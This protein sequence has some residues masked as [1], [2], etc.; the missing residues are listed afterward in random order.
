LGS[1]MQWCSKQWA[2]FAVKRDR[3][4]AVLISDLNHLT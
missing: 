3:E 2:G 4:A 1:S